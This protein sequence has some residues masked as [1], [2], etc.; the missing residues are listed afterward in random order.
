MLFASM[1]NFVNRQKLV[2][3]CNGSLMKCNKYSEIIC[4]HHLPPKNFE[5]IETK[6]I[7][8]G[9]LDVTLTFF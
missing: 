8:I 6:F 3:L 2:I 4:F 7:E 5:L 9:Q 1:E